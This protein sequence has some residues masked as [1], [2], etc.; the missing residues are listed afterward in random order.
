MGDEQEFPL[1]QPRLERRDASS[2]LGPRPASTGQG[3]RAAA[4]QPAAGVRPPA[5]TADLDAG[6]QAHA[7]AAIQAFRSSFVAALAEGSAATLERLRQA[8]ADLM[9]AAARTTIV[10]DRLNA[11]G[12]HA[13]FAV[14]D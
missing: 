12:K 8:A 9:R 7:E 5:L 1:R 4:H 6:L 3:P 2:T 10:L 14:S 13:R 11:G